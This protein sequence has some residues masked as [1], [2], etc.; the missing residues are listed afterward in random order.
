MLPNLKSGSLKSRVLLLAIVMSL[1]TQVPVQVTAQQRFSPDT[2]SSELE[3]ANK[4]NQQVFEL[5]EQGK[6]EEAIPLA[7]RALSIWQ[8]V[9]GG[10]HPDVAISLNNLAEQ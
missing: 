5:S 7:E 3:K 6:Y 2:Q 8:K 1:L 9:L 4:L 10:D